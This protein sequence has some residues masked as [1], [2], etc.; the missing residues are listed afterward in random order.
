MF[1]LTELFLEPDI[2]RMEGVCIFLSPFN[3]H[4]LPFE[5]SGFSHIVPIVTVSLP[6]KT[7]P[8]K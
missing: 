8:S 2:Q 3:F 5:E 6:A 7:L 4:V 1:P